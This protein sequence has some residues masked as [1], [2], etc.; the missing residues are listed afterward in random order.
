MIALTFDDGPGRFT[1]M[2][3]DTLAEYG[4]L[5]TFC[6]LGYRVEGWAQVAQRIVADGHEL[7]GHSW[8]HTNM[9]T[10]TRDQVTAAIIDT[11]AAIYAVTGVRPTLFRPPYGE[12][13]AQVVEIAA[14]LGQGI[15]MWSIDPR[16][17]DMRNRSAEDLY[18]DIMRQARDGAIIVLHDIFLTTAQAM[19]WV[20][21]SL[22][23][24]GFALVTASELIYHF[25]GGVEPG[26]VFRGTLW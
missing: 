19:E 3:L 23:E 16:D 17:W 8:A 9:T 18:R 15:L 21:P 7:T 24:Q 5:A 25:Y 4:G 12:F 20:I 10:Q 13:N 1:G 22:V 26:Q 11:D 6:V 2:I 14:E